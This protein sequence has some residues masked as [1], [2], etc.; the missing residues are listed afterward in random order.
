ML[1]GEKGKRVRLGKDGKIQNCFDAEKTGSSNSSAN[2][3]ALFD[4][5]CATFPKGSPF[6]LALSLEL[7]QRVLRADAR[8][9][10]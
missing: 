4:Q 7:H 10:L 9:K 8:H 3:P 5:I 6:D 2:P 1:Q